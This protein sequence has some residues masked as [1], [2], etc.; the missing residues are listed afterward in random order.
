M[1]KKTYIYKGPVMLF[2][3]CI[4]RSWTAETWA[5]S[6]AKARSNLTYR[7]KSEHDLDR[8]AKISLPG[9]FVLVSEI[10]EADA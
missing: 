2:D 10:G 7:Y 3:N 8:R 1:E 9:K 5:V 6:M 4:E